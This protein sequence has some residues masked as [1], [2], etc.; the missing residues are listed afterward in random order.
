[1]STTLRQLAGAA[2]CTCATASEPIF[3]GKT[4]HRV[5][6]SLRLQMAYYARRNKDLPAMSP[7]QQWSHFVMYGQFEG[8][9]FR[10]TCDSTP[11]SPRPILDSLGAHSFSFP[12]GASCRMLSDARRSRM[13]EPPPCESPAGDPGC[14]ATHFWPCGA[15]D[16]AVQMSARPGLSQR[17]L[18]PAA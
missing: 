10:F 2:T 12:H 9:P 5:L 7:S 4:A 11:K 1:M 6:P 15:S 8:R 14:R 18:D 3:A 17:L 13:H 16:L